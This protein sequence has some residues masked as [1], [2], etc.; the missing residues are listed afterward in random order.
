[1]LSSTHFEKLQN[2]FFKKVTTCCNPA[3]VTFEML[4]ITS[5]NDYSE[6][7]GDGNRSIDKSFDLKCFYQRNIS[8]KQREK[9]GVTQDVTDI[10]YISPLELEKKYG[11]KNFA[12]IVRN[13]YAGL[14]VKFLGSRYTL[15]KIVDL[16]P[17]HNGKE[18]VCLAYQL[19]L[20]LHS[21]DNTLD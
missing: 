18:Y 21:D 7:T 19:N 17:M 6:F 13:S 8:D 5:P 1:M 15:I 20:K 12:D 9:L 4:S 16:E 11:S 10:I 3:S 2:L 14:F